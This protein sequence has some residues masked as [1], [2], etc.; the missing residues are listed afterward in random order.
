MLL[1]QRK[2]FPE[3]RS[4]LSYSKLFILYIISLFLSSCAVP[5]RNSAGVES[6]MQNYDHLILHSDADSISLLYTP[7]GNLGG[8][9]IGRDSIKRFLSSF[10]NVKVLSQT[11]TS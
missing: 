8:I 11:S 7:D 5:G 4:I 9:A 2:N 1:S 3:L 10:K 6:A